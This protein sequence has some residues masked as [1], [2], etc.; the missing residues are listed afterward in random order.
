MP[1]A[2]VA[3][4]ADAPSAAGAGRRTARRTRLGAGVPC[5]SAGGVEEAEAGGE[6]AERQQPLAGGWDEARTDEGPKPGLPMHGAFSFRWGTGWR[7]R[8]GA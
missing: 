5:A 8:A 6:R 4:G 2:A 3:L 1:G 7:L